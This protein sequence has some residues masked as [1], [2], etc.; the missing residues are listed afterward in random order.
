MVDEGDGHRILC[1]VTVIG[2]QP[3]HPDRLHWPGVIK[4]A[5]VSPLIWCF[6][7]G[8]AL[9]ALVFRNNQWAL[10]ASFAACAVAYSLVYARLVRFRW[11]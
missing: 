9:L 5:A 1:G 3:G 2:M 10:M 11:G 8:P 7:A 4:N 6:A